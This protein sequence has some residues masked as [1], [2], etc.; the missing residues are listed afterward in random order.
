MKTFLTTKLEDPSECGPNIV[1]HSWSEARRKAS[2]CGCKVDGT[3]DA[4]V[5]IDGEVIW[6]SD[7][8]HRSEP[9]NESF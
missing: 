7:D 9:E 3:L 8:V 1:A 2:M 4:I 5:N 6:R